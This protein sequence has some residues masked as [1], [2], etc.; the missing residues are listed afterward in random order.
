MRHILRKH[1][2][3]TRRHISIIS[4]LF[5]HISCFLSL[6]FIHPLN[7]PKNNKRLFDIHDDVHSLFEAICLQ[8]KIIPVKGN[9]ILFIDEIQNSPEAV[10]MLRYFYEEIPWLDVVAAGS[11]LETL[12]GKRISFPVGRVEYLPVRPCSFTEFLLATGNQRGFDL[13]QTVPLHLMRQVHELLL[14]GLEILITKTGRWVRHSEP[15]K[16]PSSFNW[17]IR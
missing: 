15:L 1:R 4:F 11:M 3:S 9:T 10:A 12:I 6:I 13:L 8:A 5:D 2:F 17:Y 14:V 7:V 16:R